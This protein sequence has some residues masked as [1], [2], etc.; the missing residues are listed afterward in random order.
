MI[1]II[2]RVSGSLWHFNSWS[3]GMDAGECSFVERTNPN[4]DSLGG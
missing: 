1:N 3:K 4:D 2:A